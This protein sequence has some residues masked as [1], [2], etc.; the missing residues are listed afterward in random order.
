MY[1]YNCHKAVQRLEYYTSGQPTLIL[2]I[3]IATGVLKIYI[4]V[5]ILTLSGW[6]IFKN[7]QI[8]SISFPLPCTLGRSINCYHGDQFMQAP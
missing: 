1:L 4:H 5:Y 8:R 3:S 2:L 6:Y 7:P